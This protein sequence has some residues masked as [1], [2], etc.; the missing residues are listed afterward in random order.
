MYASVLV[1]GYK[2]ARMM[3]YVLRAYDLQSTNDFELI[4]IENGAGENEAGI[5]YLKTVKLKV[6][7]KYIVNHKKETPGCCWNTA[8]GRAQG[9]LFILTKGDVIPDR[10]LVESYIKRD[11]Q[12]HLMAGVKHN[13]DP[14]RLL[15]FRPSEVFENYP[16]RWSWHK[17]SRLVWNLDITTR[18]MDDIIDFHGRPYYLVS[19]SNMAVPKHIFN[20]VG[21]FDVRLQDDSPVDW[22]LALKAWADGY[23]FKY[24][25]G[26]I[27]FQ[28]ES[29]D[30]WQQK[31]EARRKC[32][33]K[34][35]QR[36]KTL[37]GRLK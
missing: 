13:I 21:G 24:V 3:P 15:G 23:E 14:E 12:E 4:Y 1:V 10:F 7:I 6:P 36:E 8:A 11:D 29:W 25:P 30:Q 5:Q 34:F 33:E 31:D 20:Q 32:L 19:G 27:G 28:V 9:K 37:L 18:F 26:A 22:D 35:W 2:Q 16:E 17:L